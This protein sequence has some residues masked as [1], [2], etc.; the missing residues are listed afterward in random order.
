MVPSVPKLGGSLVVVRAEPGHDGTGHCPSSQPHSDG[1]ALGLASPFTPR[2][3]NFLQ[4][5]SEAQGR[6]GGPQ[7]PGQPSHHV[8]PPGTRPESADGPQRED[9]PSPHPLGQDG[10]PLGPPG[11]RG[12]SGALRAEAPGPWS[13]GVGWCCPLLVALR[14]SPPRALGSLPVPSCPSR[15]WAVLAAPLQRSRLPARRSRRRLS[16]PS[17]E[18]HGSGEKLGPGEEVTAR[19]QSSRTQVPWPPGSAL[20]KCWPQCRL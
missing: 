2:P 11:F 12:C 1:P 14:Q 4:R 7:L 17:P 9:Q 13:P 18:P 5:R 16:E 20:G 8:Q 3:Q 19:G 10:P 15:P 6:L